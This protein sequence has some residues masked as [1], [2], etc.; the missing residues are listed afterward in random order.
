MCKVCLRKT[1]DFNAGH[2]AKNLMHTDVTDTKNE[3][4]I[5]D[6]EQA[7]PQKSWTGGAARVQAA[8]NPSKRLRNDDWEFV[9]F[10]EYESQSLRAQVVK[11]LT[12]KMVGDPENPSHRAIDEL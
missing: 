11:F 6:G 7:A 9:G 1:L 4:E 8:G 5:K 12:D 3:S 10:M 2:C